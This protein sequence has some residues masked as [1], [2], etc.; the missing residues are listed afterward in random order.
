MADAVLIAVM[1]LLL[2]LFCIQEFL[3]PA[4]RQVRSVVI[5]AL[6]IGVVGM[7]LIS[8]YK[9]VSTIPSMPYQPIV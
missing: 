2:I 8:L 4:K 9:E 6:V 7:Y 3:D 1:G 5:R